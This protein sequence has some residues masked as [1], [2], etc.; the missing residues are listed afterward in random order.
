NEYSLKG[1]NKA[2]ADKTK[3][4]IGKSMKSQSQRSVHLK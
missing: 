3:H 2:K 1:K 4:G